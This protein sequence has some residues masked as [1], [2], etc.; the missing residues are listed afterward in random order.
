LG[1]GKSQPTNVLW[2]DDLPLNVTESSIR[3]FIIR[4]TNLPNDQVLDIYIDNRNS[5]K[6][7]TAQCLIYFT[8]TRNAQEAINLIR[9]KRIESKKI[10]VDFASKVFVTRFSDI[11]E[12]ISHKKKYV[13]MFDSI[14]L[15]VYFD[16]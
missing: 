1:F 9:G 14:L 7:Q 5:H 2:L 15:E 11:I 3:S 8:D 16:F 4:Q 6:S 13:G 12:E 10:Q